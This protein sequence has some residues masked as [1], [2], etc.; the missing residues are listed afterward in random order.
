M[1]EIFEAANEFCKQVMRRKEA[2]ELKRRIFV[3]RRSIDLGWNGRITVMMS[4]DVY[5]RIENVERD[6]CGKSG[7]E[8]IRKIFDCEVKIVDGK[9]ILLV[10]YD[11]LGGGFDA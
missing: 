10:G 2:E 6:L 4:P 3:A 8:K 11:A 1:N 7:Q 9:G 5:R